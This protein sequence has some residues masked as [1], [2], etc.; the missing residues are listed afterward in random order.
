LRRLL[1]IPPNHL[2]NQLRRQLTQ[3][4]ARRL[5]LN[6]LRH[7]LPD[8]PN[9][10]RPRICRLLD[11]V[12]PPLGEGNGEQAEEVVVSGLDGHVGL[13]ER[14][15]LADERAQLVGGEVQP[16]EV[17]EAV[18]ALDFVDAELDLAE[19]VVFVFLEVG[20]GDFEDAAFEGVVGVL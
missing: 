16:V 3:R 17:G 1:D 10:T 7:L 20:E 6:D 13:D 18:L 4:H 2:R 19:G 14:L 9:L 12:V 15:P 8:R 11:L 5:P